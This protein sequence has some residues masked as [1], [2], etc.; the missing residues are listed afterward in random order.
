MRQADVFRKNVLLGESR[1]P[2]RGVAVVCKQK[3]LSMLS[4]SRLH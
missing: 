3:R 2:S 1:M 4:D